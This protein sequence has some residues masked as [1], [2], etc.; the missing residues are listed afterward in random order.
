MLKPNL[1]VLT[2]FLLWDLI[3]TGIIL[4]LISP[5]LY[6]Q[7]NAIADRIAIRSYA[8]QL[9]SLPVNYFQL[10]TLLDICNAIRKIEL[11]DHYRPIV[12]RVILDEL[13]SYSD[14]L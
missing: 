13:I 9:I 11:F 2:S 6:D 7:Q 14:K 10:K 4:D 5:I 12:Y 1:K 3:L 8:E